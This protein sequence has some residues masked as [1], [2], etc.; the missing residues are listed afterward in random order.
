MASPSS[1]FAGVIP[2]PRSCS[3][4]SSL[5]CGSWASHHRRACALVFSAV[6]SDVRRKGVVHAGSALGHVPCWLS[7]MS[8]LIRSVPGSV[9][10]SM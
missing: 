2:K 1:M 4:S 6:I 7:G 8:K 3:V 9:P 5:R 10:G